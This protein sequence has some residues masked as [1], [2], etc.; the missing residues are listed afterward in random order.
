MPTFTIGSSSTLYSATCGGGRS[1]SWKD[2]RILTGVTEVQPKIGLNIFDL[3]VANLKSSSIGITLR[4]TEVNT[5]PYFCIILQFYLVTIAL[6]VSM[7][8]QNSRFPGQQASG[9]H[10]RH[11]QGGHPPSGRR[12]ALN[13]WPQYNSKTGQERRSYSTQDARWNR[14]D[15]LRRQ[16]HLANQ[17]AQVH[18]RQ[19]PSRPQQ[20][21]KYIGF[22]PGRTPTI[23]LMP[24]SPSMVGGSSHLPL[25]LIQQFRTTSRCV[26]TKT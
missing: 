2:L 23:F 8:Q 1:W 18:A 7:A 15:H 12:G 22:P 14:D 9:M 26:H 21:G 6:E 13:D 17:Q 24:A 16:L 25:C 19:V 20:P 11:N 5:F 3:C 4:T 10:P